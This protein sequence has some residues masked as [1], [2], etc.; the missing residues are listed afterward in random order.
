MGILKIGDV[1]YHEVIR[2]ESHA[3]Y[4]FDQAL[5]RARG[6]GAFIVYMMMSHARPSSRLAR[7]RF[8]TFEGHFNN[9]R[10][11][12]WINSIEES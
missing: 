9:W 4:A 12:G 2:R 7:H 6:S 8:S 11:C 3:I 10:M 5:Q 1:F